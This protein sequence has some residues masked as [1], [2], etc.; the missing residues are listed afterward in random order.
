MNDLYPIKFVIAPFSISRSMAVAVHPQRTEV[1][2]PARP[3]LLLLSGLVPILLAAWWLRLWHL[4]VQALWWDESYS[5]ALAKMGLVEMARSTADD[6]HPPLHYAL[7]HLWLPFGGESEFGMRFLSVA[8]SMAGVALLANFGRR[9]GRLASPGTTGTPLAIIVAALASVAPLWVYYAQENR[10]YTLQT[11]TTLMASLFLFRMLQS[12]A[13]KGPASI[14]GRWWLSYVFWAALSLWADYFPVFLLVAHS[15]F[16]FAWLA[17]ARPPQSGPS[18]SS[19][20]AGFLRRWLLAQVAIALLY[21]P[22]AP[23]ATQQILGYGEGNVAPAILLPFGPL[24]VHLWRAFTLG[25][26]IPRLLD[27]APTLPPNVETPLL[28]A[29]LALLLLGV[30]AMAWRGY[31]RGERALASWFPLAIAFLPVLVFLGILIIRPFFHPRYM[32]I[33]TPGILLAFGQGLLALPKVR[34]G[35]AQHAAPLP[36]ALCLALLLGSSGVSLWSLQTNPAFFREDVRPMIRFIDGMR[37]DGD[38]ILWEGNYP[39]IRYYGVFERP[40]SVSAYPVDWTT[41][42]QR[43]QD[44]AADKQRVFWVNWLFTGV[45]PWEMVPF[46]LEREGSQA[47]ELTLSPFRVRWYDLPAERDLGLGE[48]RPLPVQFGE[49][50]ALEAVAVGGIERSS[51]LPSGE[52]GWAMLR[53]RALQRAPQDLKFSLKLIDPEGHVLTQEDRFLINARPKTARFFQAGDLIYSFATPRV[54]PGTPPGTYQLELSVYLQ[55]I[56]SRDAPWQEVGPIGQLRRPIIGSL[57]VTLPAKTAAAQALAVQHRLSAPVPFGEV[58]LF[59]YELSN[60]SPAGD[61]FAAGAGDRL[62]V[63]LFWRSPQKPSRDYAYTLRLTDETGRSFG[64]ATAAPAQGRFPTSQWR[65]GETVADRRWFTVPADLPAGRYRLEVVGAGPA[66]AAQLATVV[67]T[68]RE[69]SFAAPTPQY[70]VNARFGDVAELLGYDLEGPTT[71]G[72]TLSLTLHW[73]AIGATQAPYT[74]FVHLSEAS[75]RIAAQSDAVPGGGQAPTTSWVAGE[76][77][78]DRHD[79]VLPAGLASGE[80]RLLVGL[81]DSFTGERAPTANGEGRVLLRSVTVP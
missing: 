50:V 16:V 78:S 19:G 65:S 7:L 6:I 72:S 8:F 58:E 47:G 49:L 45:D 17:F 79:L 77:I 37:R 9:L 25:T 40:D 67:T 32:L 28:V 36:T 53:W 1:A 26:W 42:P 63:V 69:R 18:T 68:E 66:P 51:Q 43:L 81:Y 23:I 2:S 41:F 57:D 73:R 11:F 15:I 30:G 55:N 14:P 34:V 48:L 76:I 75:E 74:V 27:T 22:W 10:M 21:L 61:E 4:G 20:R 54:P 24:I 44:L 60:R 33:A 5:W 80:Y 3:R 52:V 62:P 29:L 64:A 35:R 39:F 70:A 46:L 71:P 31:F 38:L 13:Q 56:I 12:L 59:G